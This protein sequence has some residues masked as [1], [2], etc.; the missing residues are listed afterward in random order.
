M[1]RMLRV[2]YIG[3]V[4]HV[5][6]RGNAGQAIYLADQDKELFLNTLSEACRKTGWRIHAYVLMS[7][8]Y[9]LLLETPEANLVAGM[10]W[11]QG[12][13]TQRFNSTHKRHGHLFQ[14]RY[15]SLL[16]D[17]DASEYFRIVSNYIHL[18]PVRAHLLD[19]ENE[20]LSDYRWSSYTYFLKRS[21][22]RPDWLAVERVLAS[23]VYESGRQKGRKLYQG[24]MDQ[25]AEEEQDV[26][27][28]KELLEERKNLHK[29]WL[30]GG[31]DFRDRMLDLID[32]GGLVQTDNW[33]GEQRKEHGQREAE[34]L[35]QKGIE[36]LSVTEEE[37]L[38]SKSMRQEKQAI[39]WLVKRNTTVTGVWLA[40]RLQLGHRVNCSRA[41]R[42]F[43]Q[44]ETRKIAGLKKKMLQCTG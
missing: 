31:T 37:I 27:K 23:T 11:L 20:D 35:I 22:E 19:M 13:Y 25:R 24:Y 28:R 5:M 12:T 2:E 30:L 33:R 41:L 36:E 34:R 10:K 42:V 14:G 38:Q 26:K 39:V 32:H 16:I 4:Y 7:N 6:C 18:N 1:P 9:H 17:P 40:N 44:V 43:D 21:S 29:G 15:K 8:H 3:A